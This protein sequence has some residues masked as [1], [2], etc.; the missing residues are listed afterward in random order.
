MHQW[1]HTLHSRQKKRIVATLIATFG[2]Q[3][4]YCTRPFR[5]KR[6]RTLDHLVPASRGGLNTLGNLVLS[7]AK[8]NNT[9][10]DRT[11]AE[12]LGSS[13][14]QQRLAEAVREQQQPQRP[15]VEILSVLTVPELET[16][17]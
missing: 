15:R 11:A 2:N 12:Y 13:T 17:S 9:K 6:N 7:C 5:T 14:Y 3:C 8:C 10:G 16:T 1:R 4:Y